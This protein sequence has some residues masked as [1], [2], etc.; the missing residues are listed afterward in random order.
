MRTRAIT[1]EEAR[2][3]T[4]NAPSRQVRR[5]LERRIAKNNRGYESEVAALV[6]RQRRKTGRV[7]RPKREPVQV[8][9]PGEDQRHDK[10]L[11]SSARTAR[12]QRCGGPAPRPMTGLL[13]SLTKEQREYA[14]SR[15]SG[16]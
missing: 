13:S 11:N 1:E 8:W 10:Y 3:I 14:L 15:S 2:A 7:E 4:A 5:E 6:R 9:P 16:L 12:W